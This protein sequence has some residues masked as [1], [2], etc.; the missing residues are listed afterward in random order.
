MCIFGF[1]LQ[2]I[3]NK[4]MKWREIN[5]RD[6]NNKNPSEQWYTTKHT[7][8]HTF[9][10]SMSSSWD[11]FHKCGALC[12]LSFCMNYESFDFYSKSYSLAW[13]APSHLPTSTTK[14]MNGKKTKQKKNP[15]KRKRQW[16]Y[17][18]TIVCCIIYIFLICICWL[19]TV[20]A[21]WP[22]SNFL[23]QDDLF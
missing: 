19:G 17:A 6:M 18:E 3:R 9:N 20:V 15:L 10:L 16:K 8:T 11:I 5:I 4:Q 2:L 7:H 21:L 14:S 22:L 23:S 1:C 12:T 13:N